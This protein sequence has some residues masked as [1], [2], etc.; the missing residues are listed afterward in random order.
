[1]K[2]TG[3]VYSEEVLILGGRMGKQS[4]FQDHMKETA[5]ASLQTYVGG[6]VRAREPGPEQTWHEEHPQP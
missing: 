6:A 3:R 1:M 2:T 4:P 5:T